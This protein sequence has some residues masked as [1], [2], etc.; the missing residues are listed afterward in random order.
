MNKYLY[1][2]I[3]LLCSISCSQIKTDMSKGEIT[4]ENKTRNSKILHG[5]NLTCDSELWGMKIEYVNDKYIYIQELSNADLYGVFNIQENK[6]VRQKGFLHRG[7]GP[8][9][10]INPSLC[11]A[12][13]EDSIYITNSQGVITDIYALNVKDIYAPDFW[14]RIKFPSIKEGALIYPSIAIL[15]NEICI[16]TGSFV[17]STSILSQIN[18]KTGEIKNL[19]F[20]FPE[21]NHFSQIKAVE[22]MAYC[23]AN[24]LKRPNSNKLLY[25]C[26]I[27]RYAVILNHN[28]QNLDNQTELFSIYPSFKSNS[29]YKLIKENDCL[30]GIISQVTED[31]IYCLVI[32]YTRQ[33]ALETKEYKG[34]PNYFSDEL[35]IFN[36]NG[37]KVAAYCLD[38]PICHFGVDI[39][40]KYIYGSTFDGEDIIIRK[41]MLPDEISSHYH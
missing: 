31:F 33:E 12:G 14:N 6:L 18:L 29:N 32:P 8:Y 10:V 36:W 7:N 11:K 21:Y 22:H 30:R 38:K 35:V 25:T 16:V 34:M 26:K 24:L 23:D 3:I 5:Q 19:D 39:N 9:E 2:F 15:N 27:G 1:T 41:Y 20:E 37:E 17:N 28:G 4:I 40:N 13:G